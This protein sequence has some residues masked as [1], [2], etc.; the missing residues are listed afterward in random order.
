MKEFGGILEL[1]DRCERDL[2]D[3]ME[4]NKRKGTT[5]K[6]EPSPQFLPKEKFTF[7]R[8]ISTPGF[9]HDI[10]IS[11]I[12]NLD[13]TLSQP[14]NCLYSELFWSVFSCIRTEYREIRSVSL[15]SGQMRENT[16]QNN[17]EYRYFLRSALGYVLPGK[18][19][20]SFRSTKNVPIK[21]V[22]DKKQITGTF[23]VT[24]DRKFLPV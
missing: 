22:E 9:E 17:S 2:L 14:K 16:D 13:Q 10:P 11:L 3:S 20:F 6:I 19:I 5:G 1:T 23:T 15:Y 24:L 18:Y 7:Q 21:G 8:A 4:C 12:L